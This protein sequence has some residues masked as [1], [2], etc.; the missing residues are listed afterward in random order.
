MKKILILGGSDFQIP[1][2]KHAKQK[3]LYV[4]T[5]DYLPDNPGHNLSDEYHNV[6]TTDLNAVLDLAKE[7][8][9]DAIATFSSDPAIPTVAYVAN[10]L[11]LPGPSFSAVESLSVKDKFRSLMQKSG[12]RTPSFWVVENTKLPQDLNATSRYIVKPVDS[13]GS[14]GVK[15]SDGSIDDLKA[16]IEYAKTYSR[17]GRCIL[18]EYID[19]EQIHGDG[20]LRDGKLFHAYLGNHV[21]YKKTQSFI[22]ISTQWPSKFNQTVLDDLTLQI[23]K[24]SEASGYFDGPINIEARI[25]QAG[26]VFVIEMGARNGGNFVPIIQNR[27]TGFDYVDA[28]LRISLGEKLPPPELN[29]NGI[30]AHYILHAEQD[31]IFSSVKIDDRIK[32]FIFFQKVL[33]KTG[34]KIYHYRGSDTTI[35]ILLLEFQNIEMRDKIMA[36]VDTFV[37]IDYV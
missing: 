11:N 30:G 7:L 33:K 20:F 19:G 29:K 6:S 18:E 5:C 28:A 35:G 24:L 12:L 26:E 22:P 34:D 17:C 21:F 14:R 4:I 23:E 37:K 15:L 3:G 2:I 1:L 31:A 10:H 36:K 25:N 9:I 13:S 32:P 27:L 8:H 16:C